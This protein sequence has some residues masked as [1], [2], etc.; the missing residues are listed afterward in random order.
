MRDVVLTPRALDRLAEIRAWT[1]ER[2]G[3]EQAVQYLALLRR[4]MEAAASGTAHL[5][6]LDRFT[7]QRRHAGFFVTRAGR[8]FLVLDLSDTQIRILDIPHSQS[9]PASFLSYRET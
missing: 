7:G 4:R 5:R 6:P 3:E 1:A 2:F 9:N 8:H